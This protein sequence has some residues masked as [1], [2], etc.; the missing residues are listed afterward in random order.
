[1]FLGRESRMRAWVAAQGYP[2][3]SVLDIEP[4]GELFEFP[5]RVMQR[6]PGITMAEAMAAALHAGVAGSLR[7]A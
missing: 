3:L 5:V 2:A 6:W 7:S 1:M 4:P